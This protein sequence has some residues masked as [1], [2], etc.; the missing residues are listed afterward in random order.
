MA[1]GQGVKPSALGL[2]GITLLAGIPGE[3]LEALAH[4]CRWK[5]YPAGRRI[6]SR[7]SPDHDVYLIVSGKVQIRAYSLAGRQVTFR[8]IDAGEWFG[9][10]A[11]IDG[12]SRSA[13]VDA[14][15]EAV[16][17]SMTPAQFMQ[18]LHDHPVVCDRILRALVALVRNL[19]ERVFEF[20]TLGVQNRVQAELLRM[21]KEAGVKGNTA[22]L[23]P[24]PKHAE[25]ASKV[26]TN[27]E[28]VTRVLSTLTK[29]GLLQ[30]TEDRALV[31]TDV[32]RLERTVAEVRQS[33]GRAGHE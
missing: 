21:A 15:E 12:Q 3:A 27:R 7:D 18:L 11:A 32:A 8:D 10:L 5:R 31:I 23:D 30:R 17:A 4:N 28:E 33:A 2:R 26:G 13:D 29:Q 25:I 14:L 19:T 9:D 16:L 6:T 1:Q 20:S 24:S 22:R